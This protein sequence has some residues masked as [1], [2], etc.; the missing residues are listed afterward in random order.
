MCLLVPSY[1]G[2]RQRPVLN[3]LCVCV[4]SIECLGLK[5]KKTKTMLEWLHVDFFFS[6]EGLLEENEVIL[7]R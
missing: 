1:L 7:Y 6:Q 4:C 3:G 2:S 5:L